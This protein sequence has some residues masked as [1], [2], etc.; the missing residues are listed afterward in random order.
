M[1]TEAELAALVEDTIAGL[2]ADPP[3]TFW[4]AARMILGLSK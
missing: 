1:R 3:L 4:Q 2:H